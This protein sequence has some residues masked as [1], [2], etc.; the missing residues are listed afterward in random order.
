MTYLK[1]TFIAT[2]AAALFSAPALAGDMSFI[3]ADSKL[4]AK[5][6]YSA[7]AN[8]MPEQRMMWE[9]KVKAKMSESKKAKWATMTDAEQRMWMDK[10]ISK[11]MAK[12]IASARVTTTSAMSSPATQ[13]T[14]A[15]DTVGEILQADGDADPEADKKLLMA[16]GDQVKKS[17]L[18]AKE[19]DNSAANNA[20]VVPTVGSEILTTVSCPVGTTAQPNMTCLVTGNYE[21][22]S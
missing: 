6:S 11:M 22:V 1:T 13:N 4:E 5:S 21:P 8:L 20:I 15:N 18:I 16:N 2:T 7:G 3:S 9:A 17:V 12:D 14:L 19:S 10:K